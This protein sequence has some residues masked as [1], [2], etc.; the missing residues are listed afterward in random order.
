MIET[1]VIDLPLRH[2]DRFFIGG[3]WVAPS[4]EARFEV[5]DSNTEQIFLTVPEAME[6]D[7]SRAIAA[8]RDAFDNGPWSRGFDY[9][10]PLSEVVWLR[11]NANDLN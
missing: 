4:S 10:R 9:R 2:T 11:L 3:D 1:R 7:L 8:A 6:P 5:D